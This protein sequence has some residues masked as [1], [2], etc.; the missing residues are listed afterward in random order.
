MLAVEDSS[1]VSS[2]ISVSQLAR[3]STR[4]ADSKRSRGQRSP[5][6]LGEG[7]GVMLVACHSGP[8]LHTKNFLADSHS[9]TRTTLNFSLS[10]SL[11]FSLFLSVFYITHSTL[12]SNT[13]GPHPY[14]SISKIQLCHMKDELPKIILQS[15]N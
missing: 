14:T 8:E 5:D 6:P 2:P 1:S 9:P 4:I 7:N 11:S 13:N 10:F 12:R 15:L 3:P